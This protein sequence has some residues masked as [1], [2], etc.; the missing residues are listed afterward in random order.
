MMTTATPSEGALAAP[1]PHLGLVRRRSRCAPVC[2]A[3]SLGL[4]PAERLGYTLTH[5]DAHDIYVGSE[6]C[7]PRGE[8]MVDDAGA[9]G[10]VAGAAKQQQALHP[11]HVAKAAAI[12]RPG[13]EGQAWAP[14][15]D[16]CGSQD[17]KASSRDGAGNAAADAKGAGG[18]TA[19]CG[20]GAAGGASSSDAPPPAG[21]AWCRG[22]GGRG[23]ALT[24]AVG[25]GFSGERRG[26]GGAGG[27]GGPPA[28]PAWQRGQANLLA[29][30]S[31]AR[32][33]LQAAADQAF[34]AKG[35]AFRDGI[36]AQVRTRGGGLV[37]PKAPH[38]QLLLS[39]ARVLACMQDA[40]MHA[41]CCCCCHRHGSG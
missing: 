7:S 11:G 19:A 28:I 32:A 18:S 27:A 22:R 29:D 13:G 5:T 38:K 36:R 25:G 2:S 12:E 16:S 14:A 10:D 41:C 33:S 40:C 37:T 35:D 4:P 24:I 26:R 6:V 17:P 8:E 30:A 34:S 23:Y 9:A 39:R 20:S 3:A 1:L 15:A 21:M 31:K